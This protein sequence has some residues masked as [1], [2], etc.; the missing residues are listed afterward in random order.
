V[1]LIIVALLALSGCEQPRST[2]TPTPTPSSTHAPAAVA[3]RD[4]AALH[5]AIGKAGGPKLSDVNVGT[6]GERFM[7]RKAHAK[8]GNFGVAV[9]GE[10]APWFAIVAVFP[11]AASRRLGVAYGQHLA[12]LSHAPSIWQLK[13]PNWLMWSQSRRALDAVQRAIG[14]EVGL[15]PSATSSPEPSPSCRPSVR[16]VWRACGPTIAST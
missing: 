6:F 1:V 5:A 13:G 9:Q 8:E 4:P 11:D 15:T 16:L 7:P 2:P 12:A 14:G 3:F 10:E